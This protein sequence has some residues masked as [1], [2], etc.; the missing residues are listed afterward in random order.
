MEEPNNEGTIGVVEPAAPE[1]PVKAPV[2]EPIGDHP[3]AP[4][5]SENVPYSR[6]KEV[7]EKYKATEAEMKD[8]REQLVKT[9]ADAKAWTHLSGTKKGREVIAEMIRTGGVDEP[10]AEFNPES[11]DFST[12]TNAEIFKTFKNQIGGSLEKKITQQITR[13]EDTLK[14]ISV[15]EQIRELEGSFKDTV[16]YPHASEN[17]KQILE[18][19]QKTG[20]DFETA[21]FAKCGKLV[22]DSAYQQ[23]LKRSEAKGNMAPPPT[24]KQPSAPEKAPVYKNIREAAEALEA[25]GGY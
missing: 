6:F 22:R 25:R 14:E 9:E 12:M 11:V 23:G 1:E 7:N 13:L 2:A 10:D 17:K 20:Q 24:N 5:V 19:M 4:K 15:K 8:L 21:Y 18:F 3:E 16:N